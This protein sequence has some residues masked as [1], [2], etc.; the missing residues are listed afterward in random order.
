[1]IMFYREWGSRD[2]P[3]MIFLHGGGAAGWMWDHQVQYFHDYHCIV[4][5]LPKHG[6]S[7]EE[8]EF[9]I[10]SSAE[11][12][13]ELINEKGKGK[14]II[15]IGFSLGAQI[16]LQILSEEPE[17]IHYAMINSALADPIPLGIQMLE[18]WVTLL[19]PL[20]RSRAFSRLQSK[21]LYI[22]DDDFEK[23]FHDTSQME[24]ET[25]LR[26]LQENMSFV[27]PD[28]FKHA[29]ANILI[30]VGEKENHW[31]KQSAKKISQSNP[32]CQGLMIGGVGHGFPLAKPALFHKMARDWIEG[33][34][35]L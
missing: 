25:L 17:F 32:N 20:T 22:H 18:P 7:R 23:Y 29:T 10:I 12:V 2:R 28:T 33:R 31:M 1:M 14:K 4:P 13:I 11:K 35:L 30:T 9:S 6:K 3:L 16:A 27:I 15:I 19:F 5:D 26:I 8:K 24:K 34:G 21:V